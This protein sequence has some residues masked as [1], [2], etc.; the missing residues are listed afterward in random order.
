MVFICH[1]SHLQTSVSED[2]SDVNR[3]LLIN[4]SCQYRSHVNQ[5]TPEPAAYH[6]QLVNILS[7]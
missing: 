1:C 5:G 2:K 4:V 6:I 7:N 3:Q